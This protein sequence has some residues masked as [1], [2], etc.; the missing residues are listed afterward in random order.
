[1]QHLPITR[2]RGLQFLFL[3]LWFSHFPGFLVHRFFFRVGRSLVYLNFFS[4]INIADFCCVIEKCDDL[5]EFRCVK[6]DNFHQLGLFTA[7][8][9]GISSS[10]M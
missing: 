5:M 6:I 8:V 2:R 9:A 10:N 7:D 1:M 3:S 4:A